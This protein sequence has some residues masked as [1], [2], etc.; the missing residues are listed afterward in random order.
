MFSLLLPAGGLTLFYT[1]PFWKI[2]ENWISLRNIPFLKLFLVTFTVTYVTV[3]LPFLY[4]NTGKNLLNI[5]VILIATERL[6][7]LLAITIPFDIRDIKFDKDTNLNTFPLLFGV[8]KSIYLSYISLFLFMS[9]S[10][11]NYLLLQNHIFLVLAMI[12][13]GIFTA[14]CISRA[15]P[16]KSEYFFSLLIEGTMI[17]QFLLV[18]LAFQCV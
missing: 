10:G 12:T 5:E 1:V 3:L 6:L 9:L 4:N 17:L 7:F 14:I 11:I 18:Y 2:G 8:Q 13:S 16:N 15:T